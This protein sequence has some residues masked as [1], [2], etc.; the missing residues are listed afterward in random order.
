MKEKLKQFY[1]ETALAAA[2]LSHGKRKKVGAVLVK[3][4]NDILS[5]GY[6]GTPQNFPNSCED[7]HG[8]TIPEVLHAESNAIMKAAKRTVSTE[9]TILFV[10]MSPCF[11][12]SK[13]LIQ[14]GI[15]EVY[16][17]EEY[18]TLDGIELLKRAK[19][20]VNKYILKK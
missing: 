6:N 17:L 10:T 13:L 8:C 16:Y 15:K 18:H 4:E 20:K 12:C 5:Y 7:E 11:E 14:A 3:N 9:N 19:I 2:Q 1:M